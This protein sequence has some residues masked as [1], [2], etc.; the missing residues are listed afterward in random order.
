MN[1]NQTVFD[2]AI[3]MYK[4]GYSQSEIAKKLNRSQSTISTYISKHRC[5]EPFRLA[6]PRYKQEDLQKYVY[7]GLT[8]DAIAKI[9]DVTNTTITNWCKKEGIETPWG[10]KQKVKDHGV[11]ADRHL[12]KRCNYKMTDKN[13]LNA[14]AHCDYITVVGHSRGCPASECD[15]FEPAKN[16]GRR[17]KMKI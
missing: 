5:G 9:Y 10:K 7:R 13:L 15:K 1:G 8:A 12:C 11:N 3:E 6:I 14:G 16:T 17:R 4:Q 2:Q